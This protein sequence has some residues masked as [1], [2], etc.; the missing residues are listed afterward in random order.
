MPEIREPLFRAARTTKFSEGNQEEL[1]SEIPITQSAEGRQVM[2]EKGGRR[3]GG[4]DYQVQRSYKRRYGEAHLM[5][6]WLD[7]SPAMVLHAG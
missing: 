4:P 1:A 7:P 2:P 3:K 6:M 5:R